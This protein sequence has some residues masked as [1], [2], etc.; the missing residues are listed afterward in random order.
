MKREKQASDFGGTRFLG[1]HFS[2]K[3]LK[4]KFVRRGA[5]PQELAIK[6]VCS[7]LGSR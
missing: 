3:I 6:L 7:R 2:N 1:E 4:I 5:L